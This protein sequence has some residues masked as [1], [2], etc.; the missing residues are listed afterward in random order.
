ML[1]QEVFGA[2]PSSVIVSA[3]NLDGLSND[4]RCLVLDAIIAD[5]GVRIEGEF[6]EDGDD[7]ETFAGGLLEESCTTQERVRFVTSHLKVF[8]ALVEH[9]GVAGQDDLGHT[10]TLLAIREPAIIPFDRCLQSFWHDCLE[11]VERTLCQQRQCLELRREAQVDGSWR[12]G[13]VHGC[14]T[15]FGDVEGDEE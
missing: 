6:A 1:H 8:T 13:M 3:C 9:G 2:G 7:L 14:C 4:K 12:F 5:G 10:S 15:S 11:T